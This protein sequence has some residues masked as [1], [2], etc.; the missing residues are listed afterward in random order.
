MPAVSALLAFAENALDAFKL[1]L[2][3]QMERRVSDHI[4]H[5]YRPQFI[6]VVVIIIAIL[7]LAQILNQM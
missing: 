7:L 1:I 3:Q 2:I 6:L 4:A 5:H